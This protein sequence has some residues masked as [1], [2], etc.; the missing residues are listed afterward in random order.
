[1]KMTLTNLDIVN[2]V[3]YVNSEDSIAK[4]TAMK[5]SVEFAW[6]FRKNAKKL[7]D[8]YEVFTKLQEEIQNGYSTDAYSS[9]NENGQ[10]F[11]KPEF[12]EEYAKKINELFAQT[13]EIDVDMVKIEKICVGGMDKLEL[14][15]PD[16]DAISFMIDD[17][18]EESK[19][20][21]TDIETK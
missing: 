2:I 12:M 20:E 8:A 18:F 14:S 5:F 7:T 21:Q 11:V 13:N 19:S 16:I 1:M 4:N 15:I 6:K 10:R 3:N 17:S 9:E